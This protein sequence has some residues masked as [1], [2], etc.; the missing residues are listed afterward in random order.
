MATFLF[1]AWIVVCIVLA[2][3][4]NR[5][6]NK[7][8]PDTKNLDAKHEEYLKTL[9]KEEIDLLKIKYGPMK[10]KKMVKDGRIKIK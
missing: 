10:F 5:S 6:K 1:I 9:E 7:H 4:S 2:V 8:Y 3:G